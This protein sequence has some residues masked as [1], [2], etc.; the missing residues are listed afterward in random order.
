M[1]DE[2]HDDLAVAALD[3]DGEPDASLESDLHEAG[4]VSVQ[5]PWRRYLR[6]FV[7]N[8]LALAGACF[9]LLLVVVAV[10]AGPLAPYDPNK[11]D[12]MSSLL[13][14][15]ADHPF[16]TDLFGRDAFSRAI[17]GTR[18]SLLAGLEAVS[19]AVVLGTVLGLIAGYRGGW[20]DSGLSFLANTILG[21][22]GLVLA[23]AVVGSLG[24]GLTNAM[25]AL[26]LIFMPRFFRLVRS[27]T[28]SIREEPFVV[29]S[30]SIGCS[31][32]RLLFTHILPNALPPLLVDISLVFGTSI[33]AE[34]ALSYLGLGVQPP[35]AS[36]GSMLSEASNRLDQAYLLWFPGLLLIL[37]VLALA[38]VADGL[39]DALGARRRS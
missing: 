25:F 5:S 35:T 18:I 14:P 33:L 24:P 10:F 38:Y 28:R 34:A 1:S 31:V 13:T 20:A 6:T 36:W 12:L 2:I 32:P 4:I 23:I 22:P 21:V 37:T 9:L 7:R 11:Q 39:R 26:G 19:I 17:Y 29:A 8:R 16:G 15:S 3:D 27:S 30:V